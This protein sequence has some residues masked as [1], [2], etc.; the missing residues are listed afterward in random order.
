MA[1]G[2]P[3]QPALALGF[4]VEFPDLYRRD[5]LVALDRAF[6]D[7]LG[8]ADV[9]LRDQ[10]QAART[11]PAT[12]AAKDESALILALAPHLERFLAALFGIESRA[13]C[14]DPPA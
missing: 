6:V 2:N 8:A 3:D 10:L 4:G 13:R 12:L 9:A 11:D 14:A 1:A 5:G 7:A